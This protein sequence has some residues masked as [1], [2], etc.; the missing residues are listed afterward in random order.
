LWAGQHAGAVA[1]GSEALGDEHLRHRC[2]VA[3][4]HQTVFGDEFGIATDRG[5]HHS[6]PM[7]LCIEQRVRPVLPQRQLRKDV[8]SPEQV[9]SIDMARE[10]DDA[11]QAQ[12][13]DERSEVPF[14]RTFTGQGQASLRM[15]ASNQGK[16]PNELV[17]ALL[18]G[19]PGQ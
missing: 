8:R 1:P 3:S 18:R 15:L 14:E 10:I 17:Q 12:L 2:V 7:D 9:L 5:R 16:R 6:Q 4:I 19:Q 13:R 11:R